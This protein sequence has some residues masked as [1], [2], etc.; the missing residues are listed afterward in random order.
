MRSITCISKPT[1]S[2]DDEIGRALR[3]LLI[4]RRQAGHRSARDL[5]RDR[6]RDD[7]RGVLR[8]DASGRRRSAAV[9]AAQPDAHAAV[10]DQQPRPSQDRRRRRPH[11]LHRRHQ[12][13]QHVRQRVELA[14]GARSRPR[15]SV[16]RHARADRRTGGG[17]IPEA[18]PAI[19]GSVRAAAST[20]ARRNTSRRSRRCGAELV[21][22]VATQRRRS[23][24]NDD[25]RHLRGRD[26]PRFTPLVDDA[27]VF[28]AG[29][30]T[31]SRLDR[32]CRGAVSTCASS[33]R[34]SPTRD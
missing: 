31:A 7:A 19:P 28:R 1:S 23:Q 13:Q 16:A 24:R 14:P 15:G 2:A 9:P 12:H 4:R 20:A 30:G 17:A 18:V 11:R 21:A 3:E 33:C 29:S 25:L 34:A 8:A 32:R 6:Q 26:R 10:E 27:G 5:R 22:A